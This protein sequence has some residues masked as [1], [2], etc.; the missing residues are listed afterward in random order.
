MDVLI[1]RIMSCAVRSNMIAIKVETGSLT[2]CIDCEGPERGFSVESG[3][4]AERG[5]SYGGRFGMVAFS[6]EGR[7]DRE[8]RISIGERLSRIVGG[9]SWIFS[10]ESRRVFR[11]GRIRLKGLRI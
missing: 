9:M 8:E 10:K 7:F 4:E 11:S 6:L 2:S 1:R 5:R 3:S